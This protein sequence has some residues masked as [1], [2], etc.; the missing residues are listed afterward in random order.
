MIGEGENIDNLVLGDDEQKCKYLIYIKFLNL[1]ITNYFLCYLF[2]FLY[3]LRINNILENLFI[4]FFIIN[5]DE[6]ENIDDLVLGDNEQ[7]RK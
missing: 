4:F 5:L 6:V 1:I 3:K 7:K 2:K